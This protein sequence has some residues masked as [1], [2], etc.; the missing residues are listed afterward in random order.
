MFCFVK[1]SAEDQENNNKQ[2]EAEAGRSVVLPCIT[3]A[4]QDLKM[5]EWTRKK[6]GKDQNVHLYRKE[7]IDLEKVCTMKGEL[8]SLT[9]PQETVLC[10]SHQ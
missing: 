5:V 1:T 7:K 2:V 10:N 3:E 8:P 4:Q 6:N 9:S